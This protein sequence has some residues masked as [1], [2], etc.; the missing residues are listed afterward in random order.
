MNDEIRFKP[1]GVIRTP[2]KN[3]KD[4]PSSTRLGKGVKG[5]V[6]IKPELVDGL[7]DLHGFSHI[8]LVFHLHESKGFNLFAKP[9]L[10]VVKRSVFATRS[11]ARPNP[12]GISIVKL[13]KIENNILYVSNLDMLDGTPLLDIKPYIPHWEPDDQVKIGWLVG[14]VDLK[15]NKF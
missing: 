7:K 6:E 12:I 9:P 5:T 2:Y 1:I 8:V 14:K 10:D 3:K 4:V 15:K 13:N 11:P